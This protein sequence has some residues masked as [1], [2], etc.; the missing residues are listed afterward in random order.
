MTE[1][2]NELLCPECSKEPLTGWV[3]FSASSRIRWRCDANHEW[4]TDRTPEGIREL[5]RLCMPKRSSY[6]GSR[7]YVPH[8]AKPLDKAE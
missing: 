8:W 7:G 5:V 4:S 6:T 2:T 1:P 3:A